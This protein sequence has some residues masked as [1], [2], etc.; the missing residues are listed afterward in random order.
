MALA[1]TLRTAAGKCSDVERK[2]IPR[3]VCIPA[4]IQS[5][6]RDRRSQNVLRQTRS[7]AHAGSRRVQAKPDPIAVSQV[8]FESL[9][10]CQEGRRRL[11]KLVPSSTN[12]ISVGIYY[13]LCRSLTAA[14]RRIFCPSLSFSAWSFGCL[15]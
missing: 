6:S 15:P 4:R 14:R 2:A 5:E 11:A 9:C 8:R 10:S 3:I 7:V 12:R 13:F 1:Q